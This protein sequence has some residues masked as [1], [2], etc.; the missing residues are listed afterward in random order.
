V[1]FSGSIDAAGASVFRIGTT[2]AATVSIEDGKNAGL[3]DWGW[4]DNAFGGLGDPIV[5]AASGPQTIR[6]QVREDGLSLDQVVLSAGTFA[7]A[8]PG[9]QKKDTTILPR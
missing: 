4:Q 3:A 6:I 1:Q 5:F 8:P 2:S 7:A 9:A